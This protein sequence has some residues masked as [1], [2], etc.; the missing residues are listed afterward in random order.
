MVTA[1]FITQQSRPRDKIRSFPTVA[2]N[3]TDQGES[4]GVISVFVSDR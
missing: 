1:D 3:R 2:T 4:L